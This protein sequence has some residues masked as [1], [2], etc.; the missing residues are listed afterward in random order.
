MLK[1]MMIMLQLADRS[2]KVPHGMLEDVLVKVDEFYFPIDFL[3]LDMESSS[4]PSQIPIILDKS[5]VAIAN[6][7][8]N[9]RTRVMDMS[10]ENKKLRLDILDAAQGPPLS[11]MVRSTY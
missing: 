8:I 1:P 9:Y 3:V 2:I 11:T 6:A 5:F 4:N 10:F 7:C